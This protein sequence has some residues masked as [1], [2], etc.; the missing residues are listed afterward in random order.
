MEDDTVFIKYTKKSFEKDSM[1]IYLYGVLKTL[2]TQAGF[3]I[4]SI[5]QLLEFTDLGRSAANKIEQA[6]NSLIGQRITG[7]YDAV[8]LQ[9]KVDVSKVK[10]SDTLYIKVFE[11]VSEG[12]PFVQIFTDEILKIHAKENERNKSR[13][14]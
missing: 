9:N 3:T 5:K 4:I 2:E 6:L 1:E 7:V 14:L 13:Y 10:P 8:D 12:E 11:T